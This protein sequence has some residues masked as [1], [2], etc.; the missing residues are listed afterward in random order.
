[1]DLDLN[2]EPLD[3][4][5]DSILSLGLT[6]E[7]TRDG[8][9]GR[10]RQLEAIHA[11]ARW[12]QP[13]NPRNAFVNT[14]DDDIRTKGV[15]R[16]SSHLVAKALGLDIGATTK[17]VGD[18]F[19]CNICLDKAKEPILT[20]CGHLFCW[21]CFYRLPYEY[22]SAKECPVCRGEVTDSNVIPVYGQGACHM[23][24]ESEPK[25]PPRP[26]ANRVESVRQNRVARR[27]VPPVVDA[28]R[29]I[30]NGLGSAL[31]RPP[32]PDTAARRHRSRL[33]GRALLEVDDDEADHIPPFGFDFDTP[34]LGPPVDV[35]VRVNESNPPL[36]LRRSSRR[37]RL[38]RPRT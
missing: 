34:V 17:V 3:L 37:P 11:R 8:I 6:P 2:Q 23:A 35:E 27:V 4:D 14:A 19:D 5:N 15:K 12:Q 21:A 29:R 30:R 18:F 26:R 33:V 28:L 31:D 7:S 9:E 25:I 20:C 1:M 16:D 38:R 36:N 22:P 13:Q 24:P 10:I 32:P